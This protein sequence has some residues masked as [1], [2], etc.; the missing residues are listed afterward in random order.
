MSTVRVECRR[1]FLLRGEPY[2]ETEVVEFSAED[3]SFLQSKLWVRLTT[4]P[5]YRISVPD[6]SVPPLPVQLPTDAEGLTRLLEDV[7]NLSKQ[8][9]AAKVEA[10][11]QA[12]DAAS[13]KTTAEQQAAAAAAAAKLAADTA[14]ITA[15]QQAAAQAAAAT[16]TAAVEAAK[17]EAARLEALARSLEQGGVRNSDD[18]E[19]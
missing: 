13:A 9:D 14:K 10:Q 19:F 18:Y 2:Y 16:A 8:V 1:S 12:S 6:S 11:K 3:A 5:L 4:K 17:V 15:E 7:G